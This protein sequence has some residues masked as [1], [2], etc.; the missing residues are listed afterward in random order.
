LS[1][2][3][4]LSYAALTPRVAAVGLPGTAAARAASAVTTQN[5]RTKSF[6]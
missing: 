2:I 4:A 5:L 6:Y 1:A 3:S